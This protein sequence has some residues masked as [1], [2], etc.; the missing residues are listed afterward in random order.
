MW[1]IAKRLLLGACLMSLTSSILL[2][3]D[4]DRRTSRSARASSGKGGVRSPLLPKK[5]SIHLL[6][7][8]ETEDAIDAEN[9]F[10]QAI[11]D[12]GL[13]AGADY[14]LTQTTAHGD[15]ATLSLMVDAAVTAGADL[16]VTLSTPTLQAALNRGRELPIVFT[17]V[18]NPFVAGAGQSDREHLPNVTGVYT[19]G[20]YEEVIAAL[21]E[22]LPTAK[23]VGTLFV[24]AE[25]NTVFHKDMLTRAAAEVGLEVIAVPVTSPTE[26]A[27]AAMALCSRKI[28][29]VCQVAGNLLS[30]SFVS[31][32]LAARRVGLPIFAFLSGQAH[33]GAAV[34]VARDYG[35][36][37]KQAGRLAVRVMRGESPGSIPFEP[38]R[39]TRTIINLPAARDVG[40]YIPPSLLERADEVLR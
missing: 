13:E 39:S 33:H 8:V 25:V 20:A 6:K 3:S 16:L 22:C 9:G 18:A 10:L 26:V 23:V 30:S 37:G 36:A 34:T 24:P 27:D 1:P 12:E 31:I 32:S 40:L 7:Y 14:E 5:W 28:D 15:M 21:R 2:L 19:M 38:T 17:L 4:L 35:D 11:R 29:A